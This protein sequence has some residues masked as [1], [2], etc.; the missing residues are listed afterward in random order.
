[1][2][3]QLNRSLA[4]HAQFPLA[5]RMRRVAFEFL[6]QAH[7]DQALL[8]ISNDFS[9]SVHNTNDHAASGGTK[10]ADARSPRGNSSGDCFLGNEADHLMFGISAAAERRPCAGYRCNFQEVASIHSYTCYA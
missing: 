7:L 6:G 10:G 1:M 9:L 5:D 4:A 8:P 2:V 3:R